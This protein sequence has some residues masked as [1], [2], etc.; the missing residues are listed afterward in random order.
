[1]SS[2]LS[3]TIKN[4]SCD[5]FDEQAQQPRMPT[6]KAFMPLALKRLIQ[7]PPYSDKRRKSVRLTK[8]LRLSNDVLSPAVGLHVESWPLIRE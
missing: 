1:V 7:P 8:V 5:F 4:L 2:I 3:D 6:L